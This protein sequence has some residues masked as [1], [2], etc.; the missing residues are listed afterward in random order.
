VEAKM[1]PGP[2]KVIPVC[3]DCRTDMFKKLMDGGAKSVT[4]PV[5]VGRRK[6]KPIKIP[7]ENFEKV[8]KELLPIK[9]I[10]KRFAGRRSK[11]AWKVLNKYKCK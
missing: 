3:V 9:A 7:S 6:F 11:A 1:R 2:N 4:L 10:P 8:Y 5:T